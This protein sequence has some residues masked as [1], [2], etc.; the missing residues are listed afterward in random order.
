MLGSAYTGRPQTR[1]CPCVGLICVG[2]PAGAKKNPA[3]SVPCAAMIQKSEALTTT[4][5]GCRA[6]LA[7]VPVALAIAAA[8][9]PASVVA[10][11]VNVVTNVPDVPLA[12]GMAG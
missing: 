7:R 2:P 5:S 4:P 8:D 3:E 9:E 11:A 12:V 10:E 1:S 6:R